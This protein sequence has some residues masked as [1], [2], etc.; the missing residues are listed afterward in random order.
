MPILG[1][2]RQIEYLER[3][4]KSGRIA[5]AYLFAG[6][7]QV[8]KKTIAKAFL[9]ALSLGSPDLF[10]FGG[11][12]SENSEQG[13]SEKEVFLSPEVPLT[14]VRDPGTEISIED[15]RELKRRLSYAARGDEWRAVLIDDADHM[16][17][18][19]AGAFLKLLE[20]PGERIVFALICAHPE[21]LLPTI[22]SRT[23][24]VHFS[25]VSEK[26]LDEFLIQKNT[27]ES[28][29]A[30]LLARA[31]RRPGALASFL[32]DPAFLKAREEMFQEITRALAGGMIADIFSLSERIASGKISGVQWKQAVFSLLRDQL[33]RAAR[34]KN[35][36]RPVIERIKNANRILTL[37]E[38]TNVNPRLALDVLLMQAANSQPPI[39]NRQ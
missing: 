17:A 19:A 6:P 24:A 25:L 14:D 7:E 22:R 39:A 21:S 27:P 4:L 23:L 38:T 13:F 9:H 29:R 30:L 16:S 33:L 3:V 10:L 11:D 28:E 20:E 31:A 1:H 12:T 32:G 35:E 18:D 26:I 37:L 34:D 36:I 5:H 2:A 8:G 15:I